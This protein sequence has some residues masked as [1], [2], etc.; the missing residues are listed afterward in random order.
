MGTKSNKAGI[1]ALVTVEAGGIKQVRRCATDGSYLSASDK[2][3]HFGLA[4]TATL[5]TVTVRWPSGVKSTYKNVPVDRVVT[6]REGDVKP[7]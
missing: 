2:R 7:L 1:G 6:L 5:V 3:V 4:K